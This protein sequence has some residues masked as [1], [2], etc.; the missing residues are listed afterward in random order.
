[1][2]SSTSIS[3]LVKTTSS[4]LQEPRLLHRVHRLRRFFHPQ[5]YTTKPPYNRVYHEQTG[6]VF[7]QSLKLST[8]PQY[9][10]LVKDQSVF[11]VPKCESILSSTILGDP[12]RTWELHTMCTSILEH[13]QRVKRSVLTMSDLCR[14]EKEKVHFIVSGSFFVRMYISRQVSKINY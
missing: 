8:T 5:Y 2:T 14:I 3:A 1:M 13:I 10:L 9:L 6:V 7:Y 12:G 11:V 4:Y